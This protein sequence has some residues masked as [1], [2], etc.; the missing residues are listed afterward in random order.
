MDPRTETEAETGPVK[1]GDLFER[2]QILKLLGQGGY[3]SVYHARRE[4]IDRDVAIKISNRSVDR[5][6]FRRFQAEARLTHKL[7]HPN[8]V[9]VI[10]AD[11]AGSGHLYIVME[12]LRGQTFWEA[13]KQHGK[14]TIPEA[15]LLCAQVTEGVEQAHRVG[16]IHRDLKPLNLFIIEGNRVKVL[17]FG[18]AK[19]ADGDASSTRRDVI[20]GT[21]KYMSPEQLQ[22]HV[23]TPRSDIFALGVILFELLTG[24]HPHL[25]DNPQ[26]TA[27]QLGW[28][29]AA[30]LAPMLDE[31]DP[32]IPRYVARAVQRALSKLPEQ[33]FASM[34]E[35]GAVLRD[36]QERYVRELGPAASEPRALWKPAP[37]ASGIVRSASVLPASSLLQDQ[38]ATAVVAVVSPQ[39]QRPTIRIGTASSPPDELEQPS[40]ATPFGESQSHAPAKPDVPPVPSVVA[41]TPAPLSGGVAVASVGGAGNGK[42]APASPGLTLRRVLAL[43]AA[44]GFLVG[45]GLTFARLTPMQTPQSAP[46]SSAAASSANT[47]GAHAIPVAAPQGLASSPPDAPERPALVEAPRS[48]NSLPSLSVS[49]ASRPPAGTVRQKLR[50]SP[51]DKKLEDR[52]NWF[53]E[54]SQSKKAPSAKSGL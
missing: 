37:A 53:Q 15:L 52:L 30:R 13:K 35:F 26:L 54:D 38:I 40:G 31:L 21:L 43:G 27:A 51:T 10:D 28:A 34:A 23:L 2:Y 49:A 33:R 14:L 5:E 19:L 50:P 22:G 42:Q 18:I 3:A 9:E 39:S 16:A 6:F 41:P 17:D 45:A 46:G 47:G 12:L 7:K 29:I 36:C 4:F 1:P 25:I 11:V 8:V 24:Q 48:A 32:T 44:V 20:H